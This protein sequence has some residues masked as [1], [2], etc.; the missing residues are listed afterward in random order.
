MD[1]TTK[2]Y[3]LAALK[4]V[5]TLGGALITG[6]RGGGFYHGV[7][8]FQRHWDNARGNHIIIEREQEEESKKGPEL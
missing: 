4:A 8:E 6:N 2:E 1:Y 3:L 5:T 7:R